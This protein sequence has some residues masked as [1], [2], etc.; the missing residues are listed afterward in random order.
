M[1]YDL[2][3]TRRKDWADQDGPQITEAEWRAFATST[4]DFELQLMDGEVYGV[5]KNPAVVPEQW[6]LL[7]DGNLYT[8][9]P[10]ERFIAKMIDIASALGAKVQGDDGEVYGPYPPEYAARKKRTAL[11]HILEFLRSLVPRRRR[12]NID[13]SVGDRV[14]DALGRPGTVRAIDP[15]AE[16]GLGLIEVEYENG[17]IRLFSATFSG[18]QRRPQ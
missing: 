10:D 5:W 6:L 14:T 17:T 1:G 9:N 13:V 18:L 7:S 3:I 8:K 4:A 12:P 16:H 15:A 11:Q 2:H